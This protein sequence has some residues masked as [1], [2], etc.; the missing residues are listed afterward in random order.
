MGGEICTYCQ[1]SLIPP[2]YWSRRSAPFLFDRQYILNPQ[3]INIPF[4]LFDLYS[5][6]LIIKKHYGSGD[7]FDKSILI[8]GNRNWITGMDC[9]LQLLP[10]YFPFLVVQGR[11]FNLRFLKFTLPNR[12]NVLRDHHPAAFPA[13]V[14]SFR[15][16]TIGFSPHF[17]HLKLI[18]CEWMFDLQVIKSLS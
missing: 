17:Y 10:N 7:F 12:L 18:I 8:V 13:Q 14:A 2:S 5:F 16:F 15:Y 3:P 1:I 9:Q 6:Q 11:L 4:V